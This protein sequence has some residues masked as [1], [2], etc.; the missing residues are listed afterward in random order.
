MKRVAIVNSGICNLTSVLNAFEYLSMD[1]EIVDVGT[2]LD[3]F[4]H[5]VLPGVGA[6]MQGMQK[7]KGRGLDEAIRREVEKGKPLFGICLGMQLLASKGE[8]FGITEGLGLIPG[9]ITKM[10]LSAPG[11]KLPHVGWN[12]VSYPRSS[13]LWKGIE[14]H[15]SFYFIHSF[16]YTH[17]P[18]E[19]V[20]GI[21][22][23]GDRVV[24][25]VQKGHVFG[26]QFH[27]E[28][29]Q[30]PGLQLIRNFVELC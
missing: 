13:I 20:I 6:F 18:D 9:D 8:E 16:A 3:R 17:I 14:E 10:E 26:V 22:E 15:S 4:S 12:D 27:P 23:Y 21:C 7:L 29:S 11:L 5:L 25:A 30:K 1:A 24:A 2:K 19:Y 28:K